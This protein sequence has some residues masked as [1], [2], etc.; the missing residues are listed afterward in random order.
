MLP[1]SVCWARPVGTLDDFNLIGGDSIS[2]AKVQ[3]EL[4]GMNL[5]ASDILSLGTPQKL[6]ARV[7]AG[8]TGR[9]TR[10]LA[11]DL[12]RA[13]DGRGTGHESPVHR[14]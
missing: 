13:A 9:K 6:A 7:K 4:E 12:C 3:T 10:L 14:L 11:V 8:L 2:A 1:S 5:S